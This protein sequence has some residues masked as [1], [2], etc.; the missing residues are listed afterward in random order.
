MERFRV[1]APVA[2]SVPADMVFGA[3]R[4][5]PPPSTEPVPVYLWPLAALDWT[6]AKPIAM[7]GA[8]GRWLGQGG[9]K[10]LIGWVGMLLLAGAVVWGVVDYM[11][12]AW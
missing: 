3:N 8:P 2:P 4:P 6:I 7:F 11:G 9:G 1:E 5:V 10:A 12:W